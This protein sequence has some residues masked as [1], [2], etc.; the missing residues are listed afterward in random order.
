M[1]VTHRSNKLKEDIQKCVK[2]TLI[3]LVLTK[4]KECVSVSQILKEINIVLDSMEIMLQ[5]MLLSEIIGIIYNH[6]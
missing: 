2:Q 4:P 3:V 6:L 1:F 5:H